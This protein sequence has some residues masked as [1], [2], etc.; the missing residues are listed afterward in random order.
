MFCLKQCDECQGKPDGHM[1]QV[2]TV[3]NHLSAL[4]LTVEIDDVVNSVAW[5][6]S[7]LRFARRFTYAIK[8]RAARAKALSSNFRAYLVPAT[9]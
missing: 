5:N 6:T 2:Y 4:A 9:G 8:G 7:G 3:P 1:E